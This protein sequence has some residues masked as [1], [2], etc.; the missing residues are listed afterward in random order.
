MPGYRAIDDRVCARHFLDARAGRRLN[1]RSVIK[2]I[3][4]PVASQGFS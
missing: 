1:S 2:Q 4:G 3:D